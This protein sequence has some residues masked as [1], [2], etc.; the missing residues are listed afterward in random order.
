MALNIVLLLIL[1]IAFCLNYPRARTLYQSRSD[2]ITNSVR[3]NVSFTSCNINHLKLKALHSESTDHESDLFLFCG[4]S[5]G[6]FN[7]C[8]HCQLPQREY[9]FACD[10]H[11]SCSTNS[12]LHENF[13]FPIISRFVISHPLRL[14]VSF[15]F[16]S[17]SKI[18]RP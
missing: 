14:P 18:I 2:V 7:F 5:R 6:R 11:R 15:Y 16:V 4:Y 3:N 10:P 9:D 17:I 13:F 8:F 12:L 1:E